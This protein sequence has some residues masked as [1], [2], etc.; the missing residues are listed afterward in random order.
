MNIKFRIIL[1]YFDSTKLMRGRDF[2]RNRSLQK[3]IE[4][5][6]EVET[7]TSLIVLGDFNG[8]LT[9][10]E[11]S[12]NTDANGIMLEKWVEKFNIHHLNTLDTCNGTYTFQSLNGK[13]A[14]DHVLTNRI[15]YEK[16]I[17]MVIDEKSMMNISD[18]GYGS[19]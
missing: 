16:H 11:P 14:I 12:I 17:G 19:R 6:M 13:S 10:L 2:D 8:R 1:Y 7:D 9:K 15:L 3:Q 18:Q 4:K 5:L